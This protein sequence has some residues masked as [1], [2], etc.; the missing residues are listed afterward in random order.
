MLTLSGGRCMVCV[1]TTVDEAKA[2]VDQALAVA[3][4]A[5]AGYIND[6]RR[7]WREWAESAVRT[8]VVERQPLVTQDL[9]VRLPS[10]KAQVEEYIV[11]GEGQVAG[12]FGPPSSPELLAK[13]VRKKLQRPPRPNIGK[14]V[15]HLAEPLHVMLVEWGYRPDLIKSGRVEGGYSAHQFM[16]GDVS[17]PSSATTD[18]LAKA[19][20]VLGLRKLALAE[21]EHAAAAGRVGDL[22]DNA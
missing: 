15:E 18:A 8:L 13:D 12:L 17:F 11:I 20:Q 7:E 19:A 21:A 22:W 4:S 1:M 10:F 2:A 5:Q 9:G 14:A 3:V 6:V 16:A